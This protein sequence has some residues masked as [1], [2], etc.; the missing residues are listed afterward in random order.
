M[1]GKRSSIG[2]H[3]K[4]RDLFPG[5]YQPSDEEQQGAIATATIILDAN[6][7]LDLYRLPAA[8]R[9]EAFG[10]LEKV[11]NRL[12][13]PFQ[14]ALEY[15]RNRWNV[16]SDQNDLYQ[17]ALAAVEKTAGETRGRLQ[18]VNRHS[19][20]DSDEFLK[21]I[22]ELT[23]SFKESVQEIGKILQFDVGDHDP[24]RDR[25]DAILT[26][27]VGHAPTQETVDLI[28]KEGAKRYQD[29]IPPG[30]ADQK[31]KGDRSFSF[32]GVRYQAKFGDLLL[33]SQLKE[34]AAGRDPGGYI[35][36]TNDNK[37]DWFATLKGKTLGPR[38]ELVS[39]FIQET[40]ATGFHIYSFERFLKFA[41]E[42]L[43]AKIAQDTLD[44]V[45]DL[46]LHETVLDY[47]RVAGLIE[48]ARI[49]LMARLREH[50]YNFLD[51]QEL[52]RQARR[53][54]LIHEDRGDLLN[55]VYF[56]GERAGD[57]APTCID[58]LDMLRREQREG[59]IY[60][61]LVIADLSTV[62]DLLNELWSSP[63]PHTAVGL[64]SVLDG[65]VRQ[66]AEWCHGSWPGELQWAPV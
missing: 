38:P 4:M 18:K 24:I 47:G 31:T 44:R 35:L 48:G 2:L 29:E 46:A 61:A 33:W 40:K 14:V 45:R 20:I 57:I 62:P 30:Y 6:V 63:P 37:E 27:R 22:D 54:L 19:V 43:S 60:I 66:R 15:Q 13:V 10:V 16:I 36:V 39:E 1:H 7:L 23:A 55:V 12:W 58:Y 25:I 21:K 8:S 9:A 28:A 34:F 3:S 41:K 32:G 59:K 26:G 56:A 50:H 53:D 17:A 5:Y 42:Y 52:G 64:F 49:R 65:L 11:K 51:T